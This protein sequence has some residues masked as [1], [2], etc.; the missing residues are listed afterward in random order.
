MIHSDLSKHAKEMVDINAIV[1]NLG[2]TN[3][4]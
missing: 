1:D 4:I 3:D 2:D